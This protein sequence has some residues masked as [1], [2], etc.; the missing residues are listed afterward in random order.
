MR[1]PTI[2]C[3]ANYIATNESQRRGFDLYAAGITGAGVLI[4]AAVWVLAIAKLID[5][6]GLR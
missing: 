1:V 5:L 6:C 3:S 2:R 4:S